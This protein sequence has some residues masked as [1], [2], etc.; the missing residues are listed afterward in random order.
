MLIFFDTEFTGLVPNTSLIS[1]GM[2]SAD[3]K[4]F[5]GE[6]LDYNANLCDNWLKENVIANCLINTSRKD[7]LCKQFDYI[8]SLSQIYGR[9]TNIENLFAVYMTHDQLDIYRKMKEDENLTVS[10]GPN[11]VVREA[12][13]NWLKQWRVQPIQLVSDVSHYDMELFCSIF[14]GA[15]NLPDNVTPACFDICQDIALN[16]NEINNLNDSL[17]IRMHNAFDISREDLCKRLGKELPVGRKHNALYDAEVIK[18][19]FEGLHE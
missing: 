5:Y 17:S 1:I 12:L 19:I 8:E 13:T 2:V 18:L 14:G 6:F 16:F 9:P 7:G 4:K 3:G 11:D 10:I 15:M